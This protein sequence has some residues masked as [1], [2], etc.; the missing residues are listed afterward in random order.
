MNTTNF[1][2]KFR[3]M[4]KPLFSIVIPTYNRAEKLLRALQSLNTQTCSDFEVIVCDDGSTDYTRTIVELFRA[5]INFR[6]LHYI[7][8]L[9][10]GGPA[11]PRNAGIKKATADWI[12]FLDSDDSW[13]PTKL[14]SIL[15]YMKEF[16]L[17]Y[18]DFDLIN[19]AG[20][21]KPL[22]SRQLEYPVFEDLMLKGHNGCIFNSSVCVRKKILQDAGGFSENRILIGVEDADMWLR[23]SRYTN[24]FKHIPQRLGMYFLNGGNL[25]TYDQIMIDKL[26]HVFNIHAPY[27]RDENLIA[28]A[29]RTNNYHL[30]RIRRIMGDS[31]E[32]LK[33]YRSALGSPNNIISF[34]SLFWIV[35][36]YGK[37]NKIFKRP[38]AIF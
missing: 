15:P 20:K 10:W 32:A 7:F 38:S 33:L 9:N 31:K 14:A 4:R 34:R 24:R 36:L 3:C 12:C 11:R 22:H 23:V 25:T 30:G 28:L 16:D 21:S 2:V 29:T 13:Y 19:D 35:F 17:I 1:T 37:L 5:E 6:Q 26:Q 8:E 27:L 18:H